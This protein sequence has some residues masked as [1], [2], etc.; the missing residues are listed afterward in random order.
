[1]FETE[2]TILP[3]A[4]LSKKKA[5]PIVTGEGGVAV[6]CN[7]VYILALSIAKKVFKH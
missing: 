6:L 7:V 2:V 1:V 3:T 5:P 4:R